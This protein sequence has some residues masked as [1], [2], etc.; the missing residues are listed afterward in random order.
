[1]NRTERVVEW[2]FIAYYGAIAFLALIPV[3]LLIVLLELADQ[4]DSWW[5]SGNDDQ[6][7]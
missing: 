4:I 3:F 5:T 1:M 7:S 2:L 6:A